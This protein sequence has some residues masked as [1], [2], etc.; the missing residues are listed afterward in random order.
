MR[1]F[2][3]AA[4]KGLA[5]ELD[6]QLLADGEIAVFHDSSA[7]RMTGVDRLMEN[8][9]AHHIRE[10]RLMESDQTVPLLDDVLDLVHG[11]VPLLIEMKG[12][13]RVG[14][15]GKAILQKLKGYDGLFALQSFNPRVLLWLKMRY[16]HI[17]RGQISGSLQDV[18]LAWHR[19][20]LV[21]NLL[22]N[23][24]TRPHFI[25][26]EAECIPDMKRVQALRAKMP[27]IGWTVSSLDQYKRLKRYCDNIIF[28]G[29]DPFTAFV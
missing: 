14:Q 15:F 11:E 12:F 13:G 28:E 16:P 3:M 6:V 7:V 23:G 9:E 10:M 27:V 1:A 20:M 5:A 26:Y 24:I 19:K 2:E 8:C 21:R 25:S 17:P 29:F 18:K 22:T 4:H